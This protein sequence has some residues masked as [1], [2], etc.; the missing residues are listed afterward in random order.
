MNQALQTILRK[1]LI[2]EMK[3]PVFIYSLF[4]FFSFTQNE[5]KTILSKNK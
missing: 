4:Y 2:V 5:R 3:N 1:Y